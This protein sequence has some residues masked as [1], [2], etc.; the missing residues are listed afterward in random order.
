MAFCFVAP[1]T[2]FSKDPTKEKD[3]RREYP[4][5]L[6]FIRL[7]PCVITGRMGVD[8]A[9]IRTGSATHKKKHTGKG[10]KPSDCWVVPLC[11]EQHDRQHSM[12]EMAFWN[13]AGINPFELAEQLFRVSGDLDAGR[14]IIKE[15]ER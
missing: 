14:K 11:R 12:N 15:L 6:A 13:E 3:K 1:D 2:A 5:H 10:E 4:K 9:H 7:L 8:P